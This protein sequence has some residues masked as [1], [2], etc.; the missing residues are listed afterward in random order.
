M[1]SSDAAK[2]AAYVLAGFLIGFWRLKGGVWIKALQHAG[3]EHLKALARK[4]AIEII[5]GTSRGIK[6]PDSVVLEITEADPVVKGQT[7]SS[8]YKPAVM[9]N[10]VRVITNE[11]VMTD[12]LFLTEPM[13]G[14]KRWQQLEGGRLLNYEC[15]EPQ[16][17]DIVARLMAGEIIGYEGE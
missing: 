9:E 15:T 5:P 7:V 11:W 2:G 6:L 12:P 10:G 8:S 4:G 13:T 3:V 1:R 14:V 17:A 16:W